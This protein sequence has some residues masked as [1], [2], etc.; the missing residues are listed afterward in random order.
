[1]QGNGASSL[2]FLV[3]LIGLFYFM[4]IRPQKKRVQQHAELV[5]S[6]SVGDEV[7][8]IGGMHGTV[9]A[10]GDDQIELEIAPGTTVRFIKS[11]IS[12]RLT[13]DLEQGDTPDQS[14]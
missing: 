12:R 5:N 3:V 4:L 11:A 9:R 7:I 13:E 10:L 6:V 2:I 8:T 1:M 14:E